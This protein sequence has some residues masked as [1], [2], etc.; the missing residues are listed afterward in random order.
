MVSV[1]SISLPYKAYCGNY[2]NI[3]DVPESLFV[4][5]LRSHKASANEK[6]HITTVETITGQLP[7]NLQ[8][9]L[10]YC[11]CQSVQWWTVNLGA[12]SCDL[13]LNWAQGRLR[14]RGQ[15][16]SSQIAEKDRRS[17]F[18]LG[19]R[20]EFKKRKMIIVHATSHVLLGN[21]FSQLHLIRHLIRYI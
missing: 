5:A 7:V 13:G 15:N 10:I 21:E 11:R 17:I 4:Q 8:L 16:R 20:M 1:Y 9:S 18:H 6:S 12:F 14:I 3:V 19:Q 2:G